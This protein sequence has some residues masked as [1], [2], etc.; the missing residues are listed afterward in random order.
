MRDREVL[1]LEIKASFNEYIKLGLDTKPVTER[2]DKY[3]SVFMD[4]ILQWVF[5]IA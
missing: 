5:A 2:C 3:E 1:N 4:M